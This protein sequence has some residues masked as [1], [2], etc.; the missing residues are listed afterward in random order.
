MAFERTSDF[1]YSAPGLS[2]PGAVLI[3]GRHGGIFAVPRRRFRV[4]DWQAVD[5]LCRIEKSGCAPYASRVP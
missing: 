4:E 1:A 5:I 2:G 3:Y